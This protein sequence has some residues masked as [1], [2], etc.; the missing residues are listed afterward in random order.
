MPGGSGIVDPQVYLQLTL[1]RPQR[2]RRRFRPATLGPM[3]HNLMAATAV[4]VYPAVRRLQ[5]ETTRGGAGNDRVEA[6]AF[7]IDLHNVAGLNPLESHRETV[8]QDR[9][10]RAGCTYRD[11]ERHCRRLAEMTPARGAARRAH[12]LIALDP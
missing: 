4:V 9:G 5:R 6:P 3:P 11:S 12:R 7:V 1:R 10:T 2:R 8:Q